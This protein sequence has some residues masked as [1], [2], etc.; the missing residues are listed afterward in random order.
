MNQR[1]Q[2]TERMDRYHT[3]LSQ[4]LRRH[5]EVVEDLAACLEVDLRN[6]AMERT[7]SSETE[8][9]ATKGWCE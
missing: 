7:P 8:Q 4:E 1:E 2:L 9:R 3:D 5:K 6:K